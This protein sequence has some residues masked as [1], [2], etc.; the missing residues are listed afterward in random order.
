MVLPRAN[1]SMEVFVAHLGKITINNLHSVENN[2][3]LHEVHCENYTIEV[4]DMN[5]FSLD[6]S[7]RR[8]PGPL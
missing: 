2:D 7:T 8:V 6:T 3:S 1:N 4:K 5:L